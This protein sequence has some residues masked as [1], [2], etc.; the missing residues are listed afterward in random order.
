MCRLGPPLRLILSSHRCGQPIFKENCC[1]LLRPG[2]D[3]S[4]INPLVP[5]SVGARAPRAAPECQHGVGER[6][7]QRCLSIGLTNDLSRPALR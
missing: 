3:T 7:F 5:H 4:R 6:A 2:S 1:P